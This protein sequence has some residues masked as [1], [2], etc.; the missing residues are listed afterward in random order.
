MLATGLCISVSCGGQDPPVNVKS[1][2]K[3]AGY[4]CSKGSNRIRPIEGKIPSSVYLTNGLLHSH[5]DFSLK[6]IPLAMGTGGEE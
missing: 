2:R 5:H 3:T 4:M 6:K 1:E